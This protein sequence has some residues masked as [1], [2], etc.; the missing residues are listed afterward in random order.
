MKPVTK[1]T[2]IL[3]VAFIIV[4]FSSDRSAAEVGYKTIGA[5]RANC[6][7]VNQKWEELDEQ[8]RIQ[9][10]DCRSYL[11]GV[12]ELMMTLCLSDAGSVPPM[13]KADS[14]HSMRAI[15]QG[16]LNWADDNPSRWSDARRIGVHEAISSQFPCEN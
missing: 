16:F 7:L 13:L 1:S 4:A 10:T 14:G 12:S 6:Q 8:E 3:S 9:V 2:S 15:A 5:L 11:K